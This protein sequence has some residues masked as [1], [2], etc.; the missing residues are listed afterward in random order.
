M[1]HLGIGRFARIE[2]FGRCHAPDSILSGV[3]PGAV[4][5]GKSLVGVHSVGYA[6]VRDGG[7]GAVARVNRTVADVADDA[8]TK[9]LRGDVEGVGHF[10]KVVSRGGFRE[11]VVRRWFGML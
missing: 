10:Q 5:E 6:I 8:E 3:T 9:P 7:V 4:E 1:P 11:V 2:D